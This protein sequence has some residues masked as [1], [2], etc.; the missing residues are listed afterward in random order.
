MSYGPT[1]FDFKTAL[2]VSMAVL[3]VSVVELA[4][5]CG[6]APSAISALRSGS[7][8]NPTVETVNRIAHGLKM[9]LSQFI[10]YGEKNESSLLR[11]NPS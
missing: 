7:N 1:T 3:D 4:D 11:D 6:M 5:N 9:P 2:K 8:Q 10:S